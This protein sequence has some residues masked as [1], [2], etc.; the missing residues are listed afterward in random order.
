MLHD[1]MNISCLMVHSHQVEGTR[2]KRKSRDAKRARSYNVV[3]QRVGLTF[4]TSLGLRR[5]ILIKF[6]LD[7][8]T[9]VMIGY[10][11]LSLKR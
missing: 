2:V 10:L 4:M 5:G 6:L 3:I 1:N 8:L 9:L 11:T 7:F